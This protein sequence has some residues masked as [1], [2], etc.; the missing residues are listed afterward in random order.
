MHVDMSHVL[1]VVLA[2][3][4]VIECCVSACATTSKQQN[5]KSEQ[6]C[7]GSPDGRMLHQQPQL[8]Q[9]Q[10]VLQEPQQHHNSQ[11]RLLHQQGVLWTKRREQRRGLNT[12]NAKLLGRR[13][14]SSS[15]H[16]NSSYSTCSKCSAGKQHKLHEGLDGT[17]R[18][19]EL[20][21]EQCLHEQCHYRARP[22]WCPDL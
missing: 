18:P 14:I 11:Q 6:P 22:A 2:A 13:T 21:H 15:K 16:G 8:Q 3:V 12:T 19:H 5:Q 1:H 17:L 20:H 10:L 4:Q 7:M 9:P